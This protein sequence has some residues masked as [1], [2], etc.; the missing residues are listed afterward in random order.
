MARAEGEFWLISPVRSQ[1][2]IC[3]FNSPTDRTEVEF[4]KERGRFVHHRKNGRTHRKE[5]VEIGEVL[6]KAGN[7]ARTRDLFLGKEALYH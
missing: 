2:S 5:A 1:P 4:V 7:E 6:F 3:F